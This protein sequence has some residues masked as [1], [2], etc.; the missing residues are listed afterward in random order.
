MPAS[1]MEDKKIMLYSFWGEEGGPGFFC[2][3][4]VNLLMQ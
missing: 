2:Y 3:D 1:V 4:E